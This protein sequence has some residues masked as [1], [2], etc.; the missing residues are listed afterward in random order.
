MM[1]ARQPA[2]QPFLGLAHAQQGHGFRERVVLGQHLQRRTER[3][4]EPAHGPQGLCVQHPGVVHPRPGD[5]RQLGGQPRL[6]PGR[7]DLAGE[8]PG[9]RALQ[10]LV[11]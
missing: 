1:P 9:L 11:D 10:G 2:S 8:R 5:R 4:V 6:Q 7:V 3:Q